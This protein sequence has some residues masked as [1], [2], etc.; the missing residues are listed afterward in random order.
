MLAS[1][2]AV[3]FLT[4]QV[5]REAVDNAMLEVELVVVHRLAQLVG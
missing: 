3:L 5:F 4:K 2:A 1:L